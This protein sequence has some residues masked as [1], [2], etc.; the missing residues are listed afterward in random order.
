MGFRHFGHQS[1]GLPFG[2]VVLF[3]GLRVLHHAVTTAQ[4]EARHLFNAVSFRSA[5]AAEDRRT[6]ALH[7]QVCRPQRCLGCVFINA[8]ISAAALKG[9]QKSA[10]LVQK[11]AIDTCSVKPTLVVAA[12]VHQEG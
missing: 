1:F 9:V 12:A 11:T 2:A 10:G 5:A 3:V 4:I 7:L 6:P 8:Q